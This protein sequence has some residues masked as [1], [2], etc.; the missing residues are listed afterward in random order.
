MGKVTGDFAILTNVLTKGTFGL[1]VAS[2]KTY[3]LL[4]TRA[5]LRDH[6][7]PLELALTS[8]SEATA[9]TLH[10]GRESRGFPALERDAADAGAT[11]GKAR[12]VIEA[13]IGQ[14]VVS[15]ESYLHLT[16][17]K[18]QGKKTAGS[19]PGP[20]SAKRTRRQDQSSPQRKQ[21][22]QPSL[23]DEGTPEE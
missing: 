8:L 20:S 16:K 14:P 18:E 11:A 7:I 12:E 17:V 22:Q 3:K 2:Y 15:S 10:R 9:I 21:G 23:F 5:N 13:D 1:T 4:P 19:L 6:M